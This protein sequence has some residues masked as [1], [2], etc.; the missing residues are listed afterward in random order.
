MWFY[1]KCCLCIYSRHLSFHHSVIFYLLS[2]NTSYIKRF[3]L[4]VT[5]ICWTGCCNISVCI[6]C[7]WDL[8]I[9][10]FLLEIN[11]ISFLLF[12]LLIVMMLMLK[13][14][15]RWCWF[16]TYCCSYRSSP[17]LCVLSRQQGYVIRVLSVEIRQTCLL[18]E[19]FFNGEK[20]FNE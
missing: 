15:S 18:I 17:I 5:L 4:N 11:N 2:H 20:K 10:F 6:R 7:T 14:H 8:K 1:L 3:P 12:W 16:H 13:K 9:K 19:M